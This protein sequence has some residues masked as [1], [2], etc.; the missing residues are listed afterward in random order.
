MK[1]RVCT[2]CHKAKERSAFGARGAGLQSWCH[3]CCN[4]AQRARGNPTERRWR[5]LKKYD[6]TIA[7]YD[8]MLAEQGGGCAICHH[9]EMMVQQGKVRR[10]SIDHDHATGVIRGLL[11]SRCNRRLGSWEAFRQQ[12][13]AY[14][15]EGQ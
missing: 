10:L 11:C 5:L 6:L 8:A 4:A 14:L 1:G 3:D 9:P 12:A 2:R 15:R 13:E 7:Q